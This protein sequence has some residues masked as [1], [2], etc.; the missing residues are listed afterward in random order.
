MM[1]IAAALE[2]TAPSRIDWPPIRNQPL[3]AG[4]SLRIALTLSTTA[5]VRA[6]DA[7]SGSC[8]PTMA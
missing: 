2:A 3:H 7:A 8:T 5:R 1:Y 4:V 6:C